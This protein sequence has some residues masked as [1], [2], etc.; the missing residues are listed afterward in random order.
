MRDAGKGEMFDYLDTPRPWSNVPSYLLKL[1]IKEGV[2]SIGSN[3][4]A[5]SLFDHLDLVDLPKS[6]QRIGQGGLGGVYTS[7]FILRSDIYQ[8]EEHRSEAGVN[9]IGILYAKDGVTS[10]PADIAGVSRYMEL[11]VSLQTLYNFSYD[12][13]VIYY[14]GTEEQWKQVKCYNMGEPIEYSCAAYS[15]LGCARNGYVNQDGYMHLFSIG[16]NWHKKYMVNV[17]EATV[18]T[19][20]SVPSE[21]QILNADSGFSG[22]GNMKRVTIYPCMK[23][24]MESAFLNCHSLKEIYFAGTE[25]EWNKLLFRDGSNAL[26]N[27]SVYYEHGEHTWEE[28]EVV[29]DATCTDEGEHTVACS[30]CGMTKTEPIPAIGHS[31]EKGICAVCNAEDPNYVDPSWPFADVRGEKMVL[32]FL[33]FSIFFSCEVCVHYCTLVFFSFFLSTALYLIFFNYFVLFGR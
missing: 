9:Y 12:N 5:G 21:S 4:F 30:S 6:L 26:R 1:A 3:A 32:H 18:G 11:P 17:T 7:E 24:I 13:Q 19:L 28:I 33:N 23:T 27:V 29:K 15:I 22:F 14:K 10:I 20:E 25:E 16:S 2:T 31:Y 8:S